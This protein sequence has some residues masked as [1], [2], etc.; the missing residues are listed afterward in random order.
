MH[1]QLIEQSELIHAETIE[2]RAAVPARANVHGLERPD[3]KILT[4]A[5]EWRR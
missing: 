2:S 4:G 5:E 1:A 3:Q